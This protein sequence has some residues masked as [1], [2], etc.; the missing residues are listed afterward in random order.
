MSCLPVGPLKCWVTRIDWMISLSLRSAVRWGSWTRAG[1]SRRWRT[2]CWVMVDAPR[3]LPRSEFQR[4]RRDRH[5]VEAGVVPE[6]LVLDRGGRVEQDL[7]DLVEGHGLPLRVAEASQL[8][9][10]GAVVDDRFLGQGVGG[11][12][13][14]W[15]E[16]LGQRHVEADR[17]DGRDGPEAGQE[18]EG[19]DRDPADG[20]RRRATTGAGAGSCSWGRHGRREAPGSGE[21]AVRGGQTV[22]SMPYLRETRWRGMGAD[23]TDV[24]QPRWRRAGGGR[25]GARSDQVSR[26]APSTAVT[27]RTRGVTPVRCG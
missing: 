17:R 15:L 10:A 6:G 20:R 25:C 8:D 7:G 5:R 18:H 1:S 9:L 27:G 26:P 3:L 13:R 12:L 23:I 14:G 2:S 11:Q 21:G 24:V 19:D 16:A 22:L 4:G